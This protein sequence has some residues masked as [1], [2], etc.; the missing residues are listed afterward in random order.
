MLQP[1]AENYSPSVQT[2]LF[3]MGRRGAGGVR[4]FRGFTW[5]C[6]T[7]IACGSISPFG[8]ENSNDLFVPTDEPHGLIEA[9]IEP[10]S[11]RILDE[12]VAAEANEG[13]AFW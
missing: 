8:I 5:R 9:T 13:H 11:Q 6:P 1:F 3:E 10:M 12:L 7:S 2:T 4:R